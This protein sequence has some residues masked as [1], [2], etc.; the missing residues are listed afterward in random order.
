M[1]SIAALVLLSTALFLPAPASAEE[2]AW[3]AGKLVQVAA[4]RIERLSPE[5]HGAPKAVLPPHG[6]RHQHPWQ[7]AMAD[8]GGAQPSRPPPTSRQSGENRGDKP[9]ARHF[10]R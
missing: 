7:K 3:L 9:R 2:A 1:R 5:H 6:A 8:L 10:Q 4:H